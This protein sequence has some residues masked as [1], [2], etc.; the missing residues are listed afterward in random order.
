MWNDFLT[1][2][3]LVSLFGGMIRLATPILLAA[4]GELVTERS[5][6]LNL[7]IEGTML[8]GALAGFLGTLISGSLWFGVG[9]AIVV[10]A[11][12]GLIMA[13]MSAS[14]KVDQIVAGL[15]INLLSAGMSFYLF[16]VVT[17]EVAGNNI[18]NVPV[19]RSVEIPILAK[20]P[21]LGEV[22]FSQ[23]TLTY[24]AFLSVPLIWF[25]LYR[26]KYGLEIRCIGENPRAVDTKGV[27]VTLRQYLAVMFGGMMAGLGG[28]FLTLASAGLFIPGMSAGRG[29]IAIAIIIFGNW[30]PAGILL[31]GLFFGFL[32]S[33]QLHV[34]GVGVNFPHEF[35]LMLPYVLTIVALIAS[36]TRSAAP[37][38]LGL[39]YTRE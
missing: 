32:D 36:R 23:H 34:Q 25:F 19:F 27:N 21:F 38:A 16:R 22:I 12:W 37:L 9:M 31:A 39:P 24:I 17:R 5:G 7:G 30:R 10:G 35:L 15:G 2:A 20:I 11:L 26:T 1:S 6:V 33:L 14:L 8:M 4:M 18:V 3:V 28:S 13:F 29:W